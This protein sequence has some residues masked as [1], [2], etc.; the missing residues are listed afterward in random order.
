MDVVVVV[1]HVV[2]VTTKE[3]V[4]TRNAAVV[5]GMPVV[6]MR[7]GVQIMR[8]VVV[9]AITLPW[10]LQQ[11]SELIAGFGYQLVSRVRL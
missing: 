4:I 9:V 1:Q 10:S 2:V 11:A 7:Q 8:N 6:V 3:F 5:M